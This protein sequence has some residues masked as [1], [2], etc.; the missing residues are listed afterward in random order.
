MGA[1]PYGFLNQDR[2]PATVNPSLW[3]QA[4]LNMHNGL[5]QGT[6]RIYQIR[7]FDI[8]NMTIIEGDTG[9]I[10]I[11]PLTSMETSRAG[12]DLYFKHRPRKPVVAVIYTHSHGDHF[13]GVKGV[14]SEDDVKAGRV[15]VLAPEGFMEEAVS[16]NV[17]AGNA[18]SRRA[19]YMY[20]FN[21][22]RS[23]TGQVDAGLGKGWRTA[24]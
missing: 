7:G 24:R 13:G 18:M 11:D 20:G 12:L 19:Q 15:K 5:F 4:Q 9:L 23:A 21:L 2:A 6:D 3:R 8:A 17:F 22:P 10:V 14:V 16:E 1:D